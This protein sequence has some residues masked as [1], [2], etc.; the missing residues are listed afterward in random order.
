M[1]NTKILLFISLLFYFVFGHSQT[2][3]RLKASEINADSTKVEKLLRL[4]SDFKSKKNNIDSLY[5]YS[6]LLKQEGIK[7]SDDNVIGEAFL[8]LGY[9]QYK[10]SNHDSVL[11]YADKAKLFFNK[12]QNK[13]KIASVNILFS[14][15]YGAQLNTEKALSYLK[16]AIP[17]AEDIDKIK[18]EIGFAN[19]Y[20]QLYNLEEAIV[21]YKSA[22][23]LS[24]ELKYDYFLYSIYNGLASVYLKNKSDDEGFAN[25]NK[26]LNISRQQ[27][28]YLG[29]VVCL[30]NI[31]HYLNSTDKYLE[32]S[33][34][35]KE[36]IKLLPKIK[37]DYLKGTL[38]RLHAEN[39]SKLDNLKEAI[40][41]IDKAEL[42]YKEKTPSRIG[43]ILITKAELYYKNNEPAKAIEIIN[44]CILTSKK[45]KLLGNVEL[46]YLKLSD[47]YSQQGNT[48]AAFNAFKKYKTYGDSISNSNKTKTIEALKLQ[49]D[50]AQYE[51]EIKAKDQEI[52]LF[53]SQKKS[54]IYRNILLALLI[55]GLIFFIYRQLKINNISKKAILAQKKLSAIKQAQ[56]KQGK[57][58]ITTY[59]IQIKE[60]NKQ[61]DSCIDHIKVIKNK[62]QDPEIKSDLMGLQIYLNSNIEVN[63]EKVELNTNVEQN[64]QDFTFK[65]NQKYPNL[66]NRETQ[67]CTYL[68]LNLSSKQIA[69]QLNLKEQS[70]FNYRRT[71]R[72][73]IGI[74]KDYDLNEFLRDL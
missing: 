57:Q 54:E 28:N 48:K 47:I 25:L 51:Q 4:I 35:I 71:I 70:I 3:P 14:N 39:L 45:N 6:R 13:S 59:A 12:T 43:L 36:G 63:K 58:E 72:K 15:S 49:F 46:S 19:I 64:Q 44:E 23:K 1:V 29:Q 27:N 8:N 69:T 40:Y 68:V 26:A 33:K 52:E 30:H 56:I 5:K 55:M 24:T 38:Y 53:N 34:Y 50:I 22:Y 17:H 67:V 42:I 18:I 7:I 20:S 66:S 73:K 9:F 74:P 11:Y 21:R 31:G 2:T 62:I 10:K 60:H 37:N 16:K 32:A 41:Y 61:L 65:L